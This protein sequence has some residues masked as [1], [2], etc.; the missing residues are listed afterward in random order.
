MQQE[1][2]VETNEHGSIS[3]PC[4]ALI[5]AG[6]S[7][8]LPQALRPGRIRSQHLAN[9]QH[10][11]RELPA[12]PR[13]TSPLPPPP[14]IQ[15]TQCSASVPLRAPR[16]RCPLSATPLPA[17]GLPA[18]ARRVLRALPTTPSTARGPLSS[19][20]PLTLL[21]SGLEV[22]RSHWPQGKGK[23]V[24]G[25]RWRDETKISERKS[26]MSKSME[27]WAIWL[28]NIRWE[29]QMQEGSVKVKLAD[30][31]ISTGTWRK[32]SI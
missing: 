9:V 19:S 6:W 21:V 32:L 18:L 16:L 2:Q 5:T 3:P 27:L 23:R 25:R 15:T 17:A 10:S 20:T 13:T 4:E 31:W 11:E 22:E 28:W 8:C 24:W 30:H 29:D 12:D 14:A 26:C 1:V 7:S